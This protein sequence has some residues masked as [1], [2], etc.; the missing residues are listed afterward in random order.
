[1]RYNKIL[2]PYSHSQKL[3]NTTCLHLSHITSL[4]LLLIH[5]T[6]PSTTQ[7]T[8]CHKVSYHKCNSRKLVHRQETELSA[9]CV[10]LASANCLQ[11]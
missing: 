2:L 11:R 8:L 10:L 7:Q 9:F 6:T 3:L 5:T 1:M 4:P